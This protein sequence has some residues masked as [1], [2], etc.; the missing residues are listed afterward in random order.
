MRIASSGGDREAG[1]VVIDFDREVCNES[2]GQD[3][4]E[5]AER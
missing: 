1:W 4:M 2:E 5:I 3:K